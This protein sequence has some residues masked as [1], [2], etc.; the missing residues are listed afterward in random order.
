MLLESKR[1]DYVDTREDLA[2]LVGCMFS[3]NT[4]LSEKSPNLDGFLVYSGGVPRWIRSRQTVLI[5]HDPHD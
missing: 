5:R 1:R 2:Q 3:A 4:F